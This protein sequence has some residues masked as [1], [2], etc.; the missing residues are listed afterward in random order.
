MLSK[1]R[2]RLALAVVV[3]V[4]SLAILAWSFWPG[5]RL[6]RRQKLQPTEMQ[7]PTPGSLLVPAQR[8]LA[9]LEHS[10]EAARLLHGAD[11]FGVL[12]E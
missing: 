6:V 2:W 12:A 4:T 1:H 7:L 5:A 11:R 3:L 8:L 9:G 10:M